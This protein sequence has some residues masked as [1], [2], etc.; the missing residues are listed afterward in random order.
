MHSRDG[1]FSETLHV[2]GPAVEMVST[3]RLPT[4]YVCVGTGLGY[5]E[6][7]LAAHAARTGKANQFRVTSFESDAFL[8]QSFQSWVEGKSL[9]AEFEK[10]YSCI[11]G[12]FSQQ[13]DLPASVIRGVLME[14]NSSGQWALEGALTSKIAWPHRYTC[15]LFDAFSAHTS[16]E[17]WSEPLLGEFLDEACAEKTIFATYAATGDLKRVLKKRGFEVPTR[18][19]FSGKRECTLASRAI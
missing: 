4:E 18:S 10:A 5:L 3:H 13:F 11:V 2:Y 1:A 17:L 16:A 9:S 12:E 14:W 15:I 8:R 7:L 6:I 19:G